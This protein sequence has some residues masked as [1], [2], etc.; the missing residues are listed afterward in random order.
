VTVF[1]VECQTKQGRFLD[2]LFVAF[3]AESRG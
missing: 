1:R 3:Q 2:D